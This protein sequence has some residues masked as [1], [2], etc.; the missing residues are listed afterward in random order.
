MKNLNHVHK[1]IK[2]LLL[3]IIKL[4]TDINGDETVVYDGDNMNDIGKRAHA[5]KHSHRRC[6]FVYFD[7]SL[8]E[9]SIWTG[10]RV[11]LSFILHKSIFLHVVHNGTRFYDKHI[12]SKNRKIYIDDDGSEVLPKQLVRKKYN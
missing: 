2:V 4:V 3:V 6:V 8:H 10:H 9:F 11:V 7:K 1:D 5:L 12:S